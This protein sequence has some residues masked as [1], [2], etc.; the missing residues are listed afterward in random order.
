SHARARDAGSLEGLEAA[1]AGSLEAGFGPASA[2]D[3][4]KKPDRK[5][6]RDLRA[7][8]KILQEVLDFLRQAPPDAEPATECALL[9][10]RESRTSWAESRMARIGCRADPEPGSELVRATLSKPGGL[11]GEL[12]DLLEQLDLGSAPYNS[13]FQVSLDG[14][15]EKLRHWA[16]DP[17]S[18]TSTGLDLSSPL[19]VSLRKEPGKSKGEQLSWD[20]S[21]L[22]V[23]SSDPQGFLDSVLRLAS[24]SIGLEDLAQWTTAVHG[25]P[26]IPPV[27]LFSQWESDRKRSMAEDSAT[28]SSAPATC[29]VALMDGASHSGTV[30][31]KLVELT[32]DEEAG[33]SWSETH[34]DQRED[35]MVVSYEPLTQA[36]LEDALGRTSPASEASSVLEFDLSSAVEAFAEGDE[37]REE[38]LSVPQGLALRVHTELESPRIT[39]GLELEGSKESWLS[40]VV[41]RPVEALRAPGS[42]LPQDCLLWGSLTFDPDVL[43]SFL[44]DRPE[45]LEKALGRRR[46]ARL[47]RSTG[48]LRGEAGFAVVGVA[49]SRSPKTERPWEDRLVVYFLVDP[50]E[51]DR[52]LRKYFQRPLKVNGRRFYPW[53]DGVAV[54]LGEFLVLAKRPEVV[55]LLDGPARWTQ[56]ETFQRIVERSPAEVSFAAGFATDLLADS[57]VESLA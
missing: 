18:M 11:A 26:L 4:G 34:V 10:D 16:G 55:E 37:G 2:K 54:L 25:F 57:L 44:A 24:S 13:A 31:W 53:E 15:F 51:A 6:E 20:R 46:F 32:L 42:L 9:R 17:V 28:S 30:S 52:F 1:L 45:D 38:A 8:R 22:R 5:L 21:I 43:A 29:H 3:P 48:A 39:T 12:F 23:R 50:K 56:S 47:Q 7:S 35:V 36:R 14:L 19:T 27:A 41:H 49:D 40:A 33:A